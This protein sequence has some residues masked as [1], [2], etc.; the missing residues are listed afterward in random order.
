MIT[1]MSFLEM[2]LYG[3]I[4]I[5]AI[6]VLRSLAGNRLP[7]YTML[8]LWAAAFLRLAVPL[9]IASPVSVYSAASQ[10][11]RT[12]MDYIGH[13]SHT[14]PAPEISGSA[15]G[16]VQSGG[17][18]GLA[19][20]GDGLSGT[21]GGL[22]GESDRLAAGGD[23]L[24]GAGS[25]L[26]GVSK[27]TGLSPAQDSWQAPNLSILL[28]VLWFIV[29]MITAAGF[30]ISHLRGIR[31][32]KTSLPQNDPFIQQWMDSHR[33]RRPVQVR[34]CD[35]IDSPLTYGILWPVILL[36]KRCYNNE[37]LSFILAH[38]LAHIRRFDTLTKWFLA[39]LVCVHWFNPMV[40]VMYILANRDLELSCDDY[41]IRLNGRQTRATYALTLVSLEEHRA[42]CSPL[43]NSF[44][45]NAMKER[46]TSIMKSKK[47]TALGTAAA[48]L[49]IAVSIS[50]FWPT[51]RADQSQAMAAGSET[52]TAGTSS[53]V[54]T[55]TTYNAS[56][57]AGTTDT[58]S[59]VQPGTASDRGNI[60][61][62]RTQVQDGSR[63]DSAGAAPVAQEQGT[64]YS[65]EDY[66]KFSQEKYD[67]VIQKLKFDNYETMS[68]AEFNRKIN[69]IFRVIDGKDN[70]YDE[71]FYELYEIVLNTLPAGDPNET[72]LCTTIPA[73]L[74]EYN[75]RL[76]E[77][78]SGKATDPEFSDNA[79]VAEE[80]DVFGDKV[81]VKHGWID[82]KFTYKILD[83]DKLTVQERDKFLADIESGMKD[84]LLKGTLT[85]NDAGDTKKAE[86]LLDDI[87]KAASGSH[88]SYTG[89]NVYDFDLDYEGGDVL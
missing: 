33:L 78:Y 55:G 22:S 11:T 68:I 35:Q 50:L 79:E 27:I 26:S 63:S 74:N 47:T 59:N 8:V 62:G 1:T 70:D 37:Q 80:S 87:G 46:I 52:G 39:A 89:G 12:A 2:S 54:Q 30:L 7:K 41:V 84:A 9:T 82:Y 40:W 19:G 18:D 28:T 21:G 73:S 13:T 75:A 64:A 4:F 69:G 38:E 71:D 51:A 48:L 14:D 77:V 67:K 16:T 36:P 25:G 29:A 31:I 60:V 61:A 45:K 88:I 24:S 85:I 81:T 23:R 5:I 3:G 58:A 10:L 72:F 44:C 65:D 20:G 86:K 66:T 49:L 32:Y 83:Q 57:N 56:S 6:T 76:T 53:N 34:V 17:S 42:H 43:S 15:N